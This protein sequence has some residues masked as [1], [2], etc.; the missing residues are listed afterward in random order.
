VSIDEIRFEELGVFLLEVATFIYMYITA[1]Y[2][3]KSSLN[4]EEIRE[5][6]EIKMS[7]KEHGSGMSHT[8]QDTD[9]RV[10]IK[11]EV[12]RHKR[13]LVNDVKRRC[14]HGVAVGVFGAPSLQA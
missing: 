1:S 13:L 3:N 7:D 5:Y 10:E 14:G 12:R 2:R 9:N 8:G 11:H 6:K 4:H